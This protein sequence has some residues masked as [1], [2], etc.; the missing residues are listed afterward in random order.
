MRKA[1]ACALAALSLLHAAASNAE[2]YSAVSADSQQ[3][4]LSAFCPPTPS[5]SADCPPVVQD[6]ARQHTQILANALATVSAPQALLQNERRWLENMQVRCAMDPDCLQVSLE[7]RRT[8]LL[9]LPRVRPLPAE[10]A[11]EGIP[12]TADA[13]S[14]TMG[15][16][17]HRESPEPTQWEDATH[18]PVTSALAAD[19]LISATAEPSL[20]A[21]PLSESSRQIAIAALV[22]LTGLCLLVFAL[23]GLGKIV[24]YYNTAD[25]CW[26]LLPGLSI[27]ATM[28]GMSLLGPPLQYPFHFSPAQLATLLCG[29]LISLLGISIAFINAV[30]YN[31]SVLVGGLVGCGKN[32]V[33]VFMVF[34]LLANYSRR[35]GENYYRQTA[36][37]R[38]ERAL[39]RS[40]F[41]ILAFLWFVLVNGERAYRHKGWPLR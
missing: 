38:R 4:D 13:V 32:L 28:V 23:A 1:L 14:A 7:G 18:S 17:T 25:F 20:P 16:L 40:S 11:D 33:A 2:E 8:Y 36:T 6:L 34:S 21:A 19:E 9:Q 39:A 3:I 31:R 10:G 29:T 12:S 30:R 37:A 41:G 27:F 22:L 35:H 15:L 24:F 5:R 26:S